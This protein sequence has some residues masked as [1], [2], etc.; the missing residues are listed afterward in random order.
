MTAAQRALVAAIVDEVLG[1]L[2]R[3]LADH[4]RSRID[5]AG[6]GNIVFTWCGADTPGRPHY[7]RLSG[8]TF[9]YELDNTQENANH[10][11]TVWHARDAAGGDFGVDLLR[12]HYAREPH[13]RH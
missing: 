13:G 11:H 2:P 8:P 3:E 4:E 7:Y 9:M 1:N 5:A 10:V 12:E 6:A